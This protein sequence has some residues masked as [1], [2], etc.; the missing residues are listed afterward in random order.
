MTFGI[1]WAQTSTTPPTTGLAPAAGATSSGGSA[2]LGF[3]LILGLIVIVGV[4]VKL[5]DRNRKR[6]AEAVQLQAQVSDALMRDARLGGLGL[7]P[8]A[9]VPTW[10]GGPAVVE[11]SGEVPDPGTHDAVLRVAHEE[12][13][14][15][16]SDVHIED[17]LTVRRTAIAA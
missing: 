10:G 6:D 2:A 12:G 1:A 14:R 9:R 17:H 8:M 13:A 7:T 4:A 11:I 16:R 3:L 15:L 5:Y